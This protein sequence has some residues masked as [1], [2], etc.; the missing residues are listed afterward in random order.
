M[1]KPGTE[2]TI[3]VDVSEH[4]EISIPGSATFE[5]IREG[6]EKKSLTYID[7]RNKEELEKDGKIVGS[8]NIPC[9]LNLFLALLVLHR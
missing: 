4:C 5:E 1:A 2:L 7:V 8:F 6:L 9:N 3:P